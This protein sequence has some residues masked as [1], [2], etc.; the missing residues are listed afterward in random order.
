MW[1]GV[2]PALARV[3]KL[4]RELERYHGFRPIAV[5]PAPARLAASDAPLALPAPIEAAENDIAN[6]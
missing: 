5:S 3:V 4:V 6:N 2:L 1:D